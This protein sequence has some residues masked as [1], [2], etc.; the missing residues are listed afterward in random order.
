MPETLI[1]RCDN[2]GAPLPIP[3]GVDF[4][5]CTYCGSALIVHRDNG[6]AYT[7]VLKKLDKRTVHL[8]NEIE[9][10]RLHQMLDDIDRSWDKELE[11]YKIY[12]GKG[13][14]QLPSEGNAVMRSLSF[15]LFGGWMLLVAM[16]GFGGFSLF[17]ALVGLGLIGGGIYFLFRN[18]HK[19]EAYQK[20][21]SLYH[22]RRDK[23]RLQIADIEAKL[24]AE[25]PDE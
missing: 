15:F 16:I 8:A 6:V 24:N 4:V 20:A 13:P 14:G 25:N 22:A 17:L 19:V 10:V 1:L 7:E 12:D 2:C 3:D 9:L 23:V 21:I 5:T 11:S 18:F